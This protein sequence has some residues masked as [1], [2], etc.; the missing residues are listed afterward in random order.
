VSSAQQHGSLTIGVETTNS[1]LL[2]GLEH[3][4]VFKSVKLVV[5][6]GSSQIATYTLGNAVATRSQI[7]GT[8][9]ATTQTFKLTYET[10]TSQF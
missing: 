7:A 8:Y 3:N 10:L 4:T 9:H 2:E 5:K 1:A 6:H